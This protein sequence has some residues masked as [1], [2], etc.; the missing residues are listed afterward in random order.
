MCAA[1]VLHVTALVTALIAL[2]VA[3]VAVMLRLDRASASP[4]FP[5]DAFST[6]T[7]VGSGLWM[8]LLL[9]TANDPFPLYGP[10]FLQ[11]LHGLNPLSAGYLVALEALAWTVAAVT[12]AGYSSRHAWAL[13]VGPMMMSAGLAGIALVMP[14]GTVPQLI[15]PIFCAGAGIGTCWAFMAQRVMNAAK[16]GESDV[17]A[18]SVATVQLF[19]LAFGGAVAGLIANIAGFSKGLTLQATHTAAFW[20]PASFVVVTMAASAAG[21]RLVIAGR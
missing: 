15:L 2:S 18:S 10:L 4:L 5:S 8:A 9:S 17:A 16:P 13:V 1:Q 20:V 11:M 19:G 3:A 21:S 7:V 12:V 14:G 6:R